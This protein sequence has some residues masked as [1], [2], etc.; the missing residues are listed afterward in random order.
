MNTCGLRRIRKRSH[1]LCDG[2]IVLAVES[3]RGQWVNKESVMDEDVVELMYITFRY[4]LTV[5]FISRSQFHI[6]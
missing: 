5:M 1:Y 3:G 6:I 2:F 4:S